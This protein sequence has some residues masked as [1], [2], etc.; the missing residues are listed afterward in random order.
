MSLRWKTVADYERYMAFASATADRE[1]RRFDFSRLHGLAM[2]DPVKEGVSFLGRA[3]AR[4]IG[5][6]GVPDNC[7]HGGALALSPI[8]DI[9]R[10]LVIDA[11]SDDAA[12]LLCARIRNWPYR[13]WREMT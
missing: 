5:R 2:T 12:V 11:S 8:G 13:R 10:E 4:L 3:A 7:G 1:K 9:G 6:Q